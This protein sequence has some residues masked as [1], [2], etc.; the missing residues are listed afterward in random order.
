MRTL[1]WIFVFSLTSVCGTASASI[2]FYLG[3]Q[4]LLH[5]N[6]HLV[7]AGDW[8]N[9][10]GSFTAGQGTVE[11]T[12]A[13]SA[14]VHNPTP[15][16]W[17]RLIINKPDSTQLRL[18]TDL[19]ISDSLLFRGGSLNTLARQV[20]LSGQA[21]LNGEAPDRYVHGTLLISQEVGTQPSSLGNIGLE[22]IPNLTEPDDLG[23]VSVI[24][25]TG[26][27]AVID[28]DG[29]VGIARNWQ[30]TS[31]NPPL[32]PLQLT[33][34]WLENDDNG[35][36]INTSQVWKSGDGGNSWQRIGPGQNASANRKVTVTTH[37]FSQWTINDNILT[38][39]PPTAASQELETPE[40]TDLTIILT[41]ADPDNNPLS[42][43]IVT[44]P[45][46]GHLAPQNRE[47]KLFNYSPVLNYYGADSF[48]FVAFDGLAYSDTA[49]VALTIIPVNDA[50][51][52]LEQQ[53]STPEDNA[54]T[55]T[56]TAHDVDHTNLIFSIEADPLHGELALVTRRES[57]MKAATREQSA[58]ALLR[59]MRP[60]RASID[61]IYT[62]HAHYAGVDSFTFKANDGTDYSALATIQLTVT[63]VNDA[64]LAQSLSVQTDE[65]TA[66]N[67]SLQAMDIEADP[68]TITITRMPAHG[69]LAEVT[70][71]KSNQ[72]EASR[73]NPADHSR[74]NVRTDWIEFGYVYT[75]HPNYFGDD[76][77][78]Y[79]ADDGGGGVSE[80]A[81]VSMAIAP[82]NDA[83]V[84]LPI[85]GQTIPEGGA[86]NQ[87]SLNDFVNDVDHNPA[88]LLWTHD[89]NTDLLVEIDNFTI[90]VSPPNADWFGSET[91]TLTVT[92]PGELW[93]E[94]AFTLTITPV[95]DAPVVSSIPDQT[96][97]EGST[98]APINLNDFVSDVDHNSG[99]LLWTHD[100]SNDLIVEIEN[101]VAVITPPHAD[102][103][104]SE[105]IYFTATDPGGL[106]DYVIVNFSITPVNDA[107]VAIN[108]LKATLENVALTFNA[109]N[110]LF[111][112][113]DIDNNSE[114]LSVTEVTNPIN[115]FVNLNE[116]TVTFY[117]L[118]NFTGI[119]GFDYTIT[120]GELTATAHVTVNVTNV[121]TPPTAAADE[122][123]TDEDTPLVIGMIQLLAND[124]DPDNDN[125]MVT[126][127]YNPSHGAISVQGST[128]TFTPSDDYFGEAGFDYTLTDGLEEDTGHVT[129]SVGAVNDA[130]ILSGLPTTVRFVSG[131]QALLDLSLYVSDV[132]NDFGELTLALSDAEQI[133]VSVNDWN[134]TFSGTNTGLAPLTE[135]LTVA[136]TD[137]GLLNATAALT[138]E[139]A[140]RGDVNGDGYVDIQD[141]V[142]YREHIL[143]GNPFE[144]AEM[145]YADVNNDGDANILDVVILINRLT[146][147]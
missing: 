66:L 72:V 111:N 55:I 39:S 21:G 118:E 85:P 84:L 48:R 60:E 139:V 130:P 124:S 37:S 144:S 116:T 38:N 61:Y 50:P 143:G 88:D 9:N 135:V 136:V 94:T 86:F 10:N 92:D 104:G 56:L 67:L 96:V 89:G 99:D 2:E 65:D 16:T 146:A 137:P 95:N 45:Q 109:A 68:M 129:I 106:F 4:I 32:S 11:F 141:L 79:T 33:F 52:A 62:P 134:V 7:I 12:G 87:V 25:N 114:D 63:P 78:S 90:T 108:D 128:I 101:F 64:P 140:P 138:V 110:L 8:I 133:Q 83:P 112:D 131:G 113:Y 23:S 40:D 17:H 70:R 105:A 51:V 98:F 42:F 127:V 57:K 44:P 119:A 46:H 5:N 49:L 47:S 71:Q 75:P 35:V 22:L 54:V 147:R 93:D 14:S 142:R 126:T 1:F 28:I 123:T 82:V 125:L 41:A 80:E 120:D 102:W 58:R 121:N 117:P 74:D 3:S 43:L 145:L 81:N 19:T 76:S 103:F 24:R 31:T 30:I 77:F 97:P 18:H 53:L 20:T 59:E 107:P 115:G 34:S 13:T 69:T 122:F 27:E 91:L 6:G 15:L 29:V 100:G 73:T 26:P 36:N 132:D